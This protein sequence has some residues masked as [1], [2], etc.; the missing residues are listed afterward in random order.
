MV[1]LYPSRNLPMSGI[2]ELVY[3]A[4]WPSEGPKTRSNVKLCFLD[5]PGGSA[6]A[7]GGGWPLASTWTALVES[8]CTTLRCHRVGIDDWSWPVTGRIR[9]AAI[10][11]VST[12][13]EHHTNAAP[14][15]PTCTEVP[16]S[17]LPLPF[18][19]IEGMLSRCCR[20]EYSRF[21]A[22]MAVCCGADEQPSKRGR[23]TFP[24]PY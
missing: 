2:T 12:P 6:V 16:G 9:S 3:T 19:C 8:G 24:A 18:V 5:A 10:E 14:N 15:A 7:P 4:S 20:T 23:W 11:L 1:T 21:L 13:P 22:D 17:L